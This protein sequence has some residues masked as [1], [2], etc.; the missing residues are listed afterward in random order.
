MITNCKIIIRDFKKHT[1]KQFISA[2]KEAQ[3][4]EE[5]RVS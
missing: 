4:A 1:S 2:I 3:E 5:N